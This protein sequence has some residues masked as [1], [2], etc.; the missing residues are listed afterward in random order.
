MSRECSIGWPRHLGQICRANL[1]LQ[2][3]DVVLILRV[4]KVNLFSCEQLP[5][6]IV[7]LIFSVRAESLLSTDGTSCAC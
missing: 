7:L 5:V 4:T 3:I 2:V 1:F 6:S